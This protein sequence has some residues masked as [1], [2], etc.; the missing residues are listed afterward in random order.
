MSDLL[1]YGS[2]GYTGRLI[3]QQA[4]VDG[5]D[6]IL[7]GRTAEKV[8]DQAEELGCR[9]RVFEAKNPRTVAD[10]LEGVEVVLNCAG[11]FAHTADPIV[12]GCIETGTHYLDITGEWHVFRDIAERGEDADAA[13]V[14]LLPG[15]GFDVV[16]SDCLAAH[17]HDRLPSAT[18]LSLALGGLGGMSR[19]TAMT[20]V[21]NI[22]EGGVVREDG[23]IVQVPQ[24]YR[25]REIEFSYGERSTMTIPWGDVFTAYHSTGI[26]NVQVYSETHPKTINRLRKFRKLAPVLGTAP[27]QKLLKWLVNRRVK[28][29]DD[30]QLREGRGEIWGEATDGEKTVV[31]RLETPN[32]YALTRDTALLTTKRALDGDLKTGYQTPSTAYGKDLVLE[33][34]GVER[35][36]VGGT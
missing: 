4:T 5:L 32:G 29:P 20:M 21:E 11:P 19:G 9:S 7:A 31:S 23:E 10:Y 28:G 3:A 6:P 34:D 17:L 25:D 26:P 24:A 22:A 8:H 2:Y 15:V 33:V 12:E 1:I 14:M 35:V 27:A 13:G 30:E 16:P 18:D 36:D